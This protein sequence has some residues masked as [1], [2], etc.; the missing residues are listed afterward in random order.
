VGRLAV[1]HLSEP[2]PAGLRDQVSLAISL[3]DPGGASHRRRLRPA[4]RRGSLQLVAGLFIVLAAGGTLMGLFGTGGTTDPP[5]IAT[6]V[7]MFT[8]GAPPSTALLAGERRVVN[9]QPIMVR[10]YMVHGKETIVATSMKPLPMPAT[11]HLL[12]GSSLRTWM[13]T[14]GSLALYGINRPAGQLSMFVVAAMPM[15]ELPQVAAQLHLI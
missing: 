15:A 11:S 2:A 14:D 3:G 5:Q 4:H 8:P 7:A 6:V 10:A 1:E 13:A 9:R 12:A